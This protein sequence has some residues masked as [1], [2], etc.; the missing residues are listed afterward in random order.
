MMSMHRSHLSLVLCAAVLGLSLGC[1]TA[2]AQ[3][4]HGFYRKYKPPPP[5]AQIT[6]TILRND[7]GTPIANAAV[8]FHPLKNGKDQGGMELKSDQDGKATI[9]VIP[10]GDTVLVQI[11]AKGYQTYGKIYKITKAQDAMKIRM[12]L[13]QPEYSIYK[14]HNAAADPGQGSGSG[15]AANPDKEPNSTPSPDTPAS[16]P[17]ASAKDNPS[18][19]AKQDAQEGSGQ[20]QSQQK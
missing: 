5:T 12:K 7:D 16:K 17:P 14:N 6:V 11:V 13:P 3:D 19:T 15:Q 18:S 10:I 4:R 8:I 2:G 9:G 20:S 1:P